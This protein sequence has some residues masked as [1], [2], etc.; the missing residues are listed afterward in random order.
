MAEPTSTAAAVT[1]ASAAISTSALTAFGVPLGLR[2][3]VLLAG[4]LGSLIAIILLNTV[5]GN[6]DTWRDMVRLAV[7]RMSVAWASS[8]TAGYLTPLVLLVAIVPE[9]VLLPMACLV[10][11]GAQSFL[12]ALIGKYLPKPNQ[13]ER[14]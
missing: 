8:I 14:G 3:D 7:R 2:A 9:T 6:S 1:I 4:F 10:G 11:A 12:R 13:A 5:P